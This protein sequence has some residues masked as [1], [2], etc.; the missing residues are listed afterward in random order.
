MVIPPSHSVDAKT[1]M[2]HLVCG[3]KRRAVGQLVVHSLSLIPRN[4]QVVVLDVTRLITY[5]K[6]AHGDEPPPCCRALESLLEVGTEVRNFLH[7]ELECHSLPLVGTEVPIF[8][9]AWNW[10]AV[11]V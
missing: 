4:Y 1:L 7:A 5:V 10:S 6:N 11:A 9:L 2:Y 3:K 8:F